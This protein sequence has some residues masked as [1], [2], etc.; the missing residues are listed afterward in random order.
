MVFDDSLS[1]VDAAVDAL[2]PQA[3]RLAAIPNAR[4]VLINFFM[5]T[6]SL[7]TLYT[8]PHTTALKR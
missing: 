8:N 7:Y 6:S 2:L 5:M 4:T 1:A 3:A